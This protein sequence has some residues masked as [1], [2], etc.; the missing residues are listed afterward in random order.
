MADTQISGGFPFFG[1]RMLFIAVILI[2]LF[3][4]F[5]LVATPGFGG[6]FGGIF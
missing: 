2:I 5:V 6:G 3:F 4:F 1:R